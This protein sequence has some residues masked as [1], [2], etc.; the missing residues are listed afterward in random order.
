MP[1][2]RRIARIDL[3]AFATNVAGASSFDGRADAYGHS[4]EL[5]APVAHAAGVRE[6][7]V[8]DDRDATIAAAAGLTPVVGRLS[9]AAL[10]DVDAY[11]LAGGTPVMTLT[12]EII[13]VK[14]VGAGAGVSY[15][16]TFRTE[17][18]THL[19]LVGLGYADGIPRLASNRAEVAIAGRR[20]PVVGRVAMDQFV[21][22]TG[23]VAA[24]PGDEV[25]LFGAGSTD[26]VPRASEWGAWTGR[27]ARAVTAGLGPRIRREARA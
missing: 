27:A 8:S 26:D 19:A 24:E 11:G 1:G 5:V 23:Q 18:P 13:A 12:G 17:A 22:D 16:Y 20:L 14:R 6:V 25:V 21:V 15:G 4:L 10:P 2:I 9:P 3:E 7:L